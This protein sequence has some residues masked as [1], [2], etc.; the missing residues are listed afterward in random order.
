[1]PS[2]RWMVARLRGLQE[3][4]LAAG[5]HRDDSWR[6]WAPPVSL[7]RGESFNQESLR[8]LAGPLR[9]NGYLVP[10]DVTLRRDPEN[11]HDFDAV[12]VEVNGELAGYIAKEFAANLSWLLDGLS[13]PEYVVAGIVR[14]GYS[15]HPHLGVMLW[16]D[17]RLS[18]GPLIPIHR[19][20]RARGWPPSRSEGI[21]RPA[22]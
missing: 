2:P 8:T 19:R 13:C 10:V 7:V 20:W 11:E 15:K 18:K 6:R 12:R 21:E 22:R 16:L 3:P 1:M 14:G 4:S 9:R 5:W 17:R